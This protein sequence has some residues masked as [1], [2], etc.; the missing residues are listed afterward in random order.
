MQIKSN[1]WKHETS[2]GVLFIKK[3]EN[4]AVADKVK[5]IHQQL[6][7]IQFPYV[8]PIKK[9][10][11]PELLVQKWLKNSVSAD[12]SNAQHRKSSLKILKALHETCN[13]IDWKSNYL[14][15]R[16]HL[17]RKWSA[18]LEKFLLNERDLLPYLQHSYHDIT[19]FAKRVLNQIR[20][21]KLEKSAKLTLLHGDVVHHNFLV[22]D[23][24]NMKLIDFDLAT[25]GDPAEELILW[26]HRALPNVDYDVRFLINE[27]PY[28]KEIGLRKI[29]CLQ[30]PNELLREWLFVLQ[31]GELE[32]EAF[33]D[34]LMPFTEKALRHWPDLV[35]ETE[36][37]QSS[38]NF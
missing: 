6:E 7:Q 36:K 33:L 12:F 11:E 5:Y 23:D 9:S 8:I 28:L 2:T 24:G 31:L 14:I 27:N 32:R 19:L 16:Q 34:Y 37:I 35:K 29:H 20:K 4:L 25:I 1:I 10:K 3:Y 17:L 18:R 22:C 13:V 15:S 21:Q 30:Y 38:S 26:M